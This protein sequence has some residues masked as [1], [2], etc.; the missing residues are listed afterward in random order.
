MLVITN[1]Q[2]FRMKKRRMFVKATHHGKKFI[3]KTMILQV[4]PQDEIHRLFSEVR[5]C[6]L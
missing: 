3:A 4:V 1:E 6:I 5:Y 2:P